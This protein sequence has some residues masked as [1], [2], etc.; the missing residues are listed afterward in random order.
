MLC[1]ITATIDH[2]LYTVCACVSVRCVSVSCV[3]VC[4]VCVSVRERV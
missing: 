2:F 3:C 4:C 1:I